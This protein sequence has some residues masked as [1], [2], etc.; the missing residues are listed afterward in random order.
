V[1]VDAAIRCDRV[2]A[3]RN[4]DPLF[5]QPVYPKYINRY[6]LRSG[7]PNYLLHNCCTSGTMSQMEV[8]KS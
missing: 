2:T 1:S 4:P 7:T 3:L 6:V 5:D 8:E